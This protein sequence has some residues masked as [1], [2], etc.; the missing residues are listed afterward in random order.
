MGRVTSK[1]TRR[2]L[3]DDMLKGDRQA[4]ARLCSL[5]ER[6]ASQVPELM[7]AIHSHTG[8]AYCI[9]VTGPP[10][11]GK[12]TL[13]NQ[14]VQVFRR[15]GAT[16]GVLAVD[17]TS[18][19]RGGAVLGDRIRMRRHFL[20]EGVFIRSLATR[21]A[22]GGLSA[23]TGAAIRLLDAFG[24][25]LVLLET[26]GIG[27]T[28]LEAMN[29]ADTVVVTLVP[30]AG[31]AVQV[32]KAGLME[33]A[34]IFVVNKA[35]RQGAD[36]LA[37]IIKAEP[38]PATLEG[39]WMPPVLRTQAH[40]GVGIEQ[41]YEAVLEHGRVSEE[42]SDLERRRSER[43]K[44]EFTRA[45]RDSIEAKVSELQHQV[46]DLGVML[47][48]VETGDVDP[49]SAAAEAISSLDMAALMGDKPSSR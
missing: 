29:M 9:G 39:R 38:R 21:G 27:Q 16:V 20:D 31:D 10:G 6:D 48:R 41:L 1:N 45:L 25:D 13:V 2:K 23:V 49:Y 44:H 11:S 42:T 14:L 34:D 12:S 26:V 35:D 5:L 37:A 19:I 46:D 32:L 8:E 7:A 33:I 47:K 15:D 40:R 28:E 43:R 22:H 30:E 17:P 4:L 24:I 3:I 36:R 18:P